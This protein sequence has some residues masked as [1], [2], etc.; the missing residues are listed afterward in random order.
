M[1]SLKLSYSRVLR[2]S[3]QT[4]WLMIRNMLHPAW[5][6]YV[7]L[8]LQLEVDSSMI[9]DPSNRIVGG[10]DAGWWK[11]RIAGHLQ[12]IESSWLTPDTPGISPHKYHWLLIK[13]YPAFYFPQGSLF[14][15]FSFWLLSFLLLLSALLHLWNSN[16][17]GWQ[18]A[19]RVHPQIG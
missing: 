13:S 15:L 19:G 3:Y 5:R 11:S 4:L 8:C 12:P 17:G 10:M 14:F 7:I 9:N 2:Y 18:K 16:W 6:W 1:H